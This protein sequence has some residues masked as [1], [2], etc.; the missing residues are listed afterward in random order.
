MSY[1]F[2]ALQRA[3]A[4]RSGASP[5]KS[6]ESLVDLVQGAEPEVGRKPSVTERSGEGLP[7]NDDV[8]V[9]LLRVIEQEVERKQLATERSGESLPKNAGLVADEQAAEPES[10]RQ[11]PV[12]ELR[13]AAAPAPQPAG[14]FASA[15]VLSPALPP[16]SRLAVSYTHLDVYKR[17]DQGIRPPTP[18]A[19][20]GAVFLRLGAD[21]GNE[22]DDPRC[23]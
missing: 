6:V 8:V 21:M 22:L 15:K 3:E 10:E 12:S 14:M 7:K 11:Q 16:D 2:E 4:E 13:P 5:A 20:P 17:Q 18:V 9:D 23:V 19:I 1:I